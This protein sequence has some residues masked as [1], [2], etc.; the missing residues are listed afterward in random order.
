[1]AFEEE[2]GLAEDEI[3]PDKKRVGSVGLIQMVFGFFAN[4]IGA[5]LSLILMLVIYGM[6]QGLILGFVVGQDEVILSA[7]LASDPFSYFLNVYDLGQIGTDLSMLVAPIA[8]GAVLMLGGFIISILVIGGAIKFTLE[9]HEGRDT[10]V[11]QSISAAM[12]RLIPLFI[13]QLIVS[14]VTSILIRPLG[15]I[16]YLM[17]STND[18]DYL[19]TLSGVSILLMLPIL[20]SYTLLLVA[21]AFVMDTDAGPFRSLWGSIT[22]TSR[23]LVYSIVSVLVFMVVI[24]ILQIAIEFIAVF[25]LGA[26]GFLISAFVYQVLALPLIY[27][28]QATF[29]K[30]LDIAPTRSEAQDLW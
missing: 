25:L 7:L 26:Y 9:R 23:N 16:S 17:N 1:M 24:F 5:Y 20:L 29:Y 15:P 18:L 22:N 28:F 10:T 2:L 19:T 8:V 12:A 14:M 4:R 13:V 11:A 27:I 6:L 21:M 30:Q 3:R